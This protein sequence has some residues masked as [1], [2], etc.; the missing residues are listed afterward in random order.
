MEKSKEIR[1]AEALYLQLTDE[2]AVSAQDGNQRPD[3]GTEK[4]FNTRVAVAK[5]NKAK[6]IMTEYDFE[7]LSYKSA[8]EKVY[9]DLMAKEKFEQ[10][11][12]FA[13]ALGL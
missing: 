11:I 10:A 3:Y 4:I 1:A 7:Q 6:A 5:A 8:C 9:N 2:L 13:K 12:A